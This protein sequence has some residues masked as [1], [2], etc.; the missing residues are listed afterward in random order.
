MELDTGT[1][2]QQNST[3]SSQNMPSVVSIHNKYN[4]T[5]THFTSGFKKTRL[6]KT[7]PSGFFGVSLGFWVFWTSRKNR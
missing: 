5:T 1:M 6:K 4:D 2:P 3:N 7:Q